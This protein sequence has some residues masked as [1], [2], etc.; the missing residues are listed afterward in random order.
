MVELLEYERR[1]ARED[2]RNLEEALEE[3]QRALSGNNEEF[4]KIHRSLQDENLML[5]KQLQNAKQ[6]LAREKERT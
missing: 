6:N 5:K 4:A 1:H 3:S 2:K